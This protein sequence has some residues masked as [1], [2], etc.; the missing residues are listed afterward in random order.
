[1]TLVVL[2]QM[3]MTEREENLRL[4]ELLRNKEHTIAILEMK[5]SELVK[6]HDV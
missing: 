6:H 3:L 4:Q 2:M 1:M 5:I